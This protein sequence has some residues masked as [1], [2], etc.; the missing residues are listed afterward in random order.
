MFYCIEVSPDHMFY[1]IEVSPDYRFYC[2]GVVV[3]DYI[4]YY[5]T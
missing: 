2:T 3:P 4:L 5:F 1:C